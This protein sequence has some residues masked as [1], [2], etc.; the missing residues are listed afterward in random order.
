MSFLN[1][2]RNGSRR[3]SPVLPSCMRSS[4][5][6]VDPSWPTLR[7][8]SSVQSVSFWPLWPS[9][10]AGLTI[11]T[12]W[13]A[14]YSLSPSVHHE[15]SAGASIWSRSIWDGEEICQIAQCF[16]TEP[17]TGAMCP[18]VKNPARSG[19]LAGIWPSI[20]LCLAFAHSL[21]WW[22][23][24]KERWYHVTTSHKANSKKGQAPWR[25]LTVVTLVSLPLCPLSRQSR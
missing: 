10:L 2:Q 13:Y 23:C 1:L 11:L 3:H 14:L 25:L 22:S 18:A 15:H 8:L 4:I 24:C 17:G 9:S 12:L 5:P 16:P 6:M 21:A 7:S 20:N 19:P